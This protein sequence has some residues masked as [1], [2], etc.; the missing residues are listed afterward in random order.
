MRIRDLMR[1]AIWLKHLQAEQAREESVRRT[2]SISNGLLELCVVDLPCA[3]EAIRKAEALVSSPLI[4]PTVFVSP[5]VWTPS[6]QWRQKEALKQSVVH[7][8]EEIRAG[9]KVRAQMRFAIEPEGHGG[10]VVNALKKLDLSSMT[11]MEAYVKLGE[12][13]KKAGEGSGEDKGT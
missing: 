11:P 13:K 8:I 12:L 4:D 10:N 2:A 3:N 7:I 1:D 5:K 9:K 6:H